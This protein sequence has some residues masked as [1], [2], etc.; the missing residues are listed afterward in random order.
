VFRRIRR[1][2]VKI[3]VLNNK[4]RQVRKGSHL[5]AGP[6]H[7]SISP[8]PRGQGEAIDVMRLIV[9]LVVALL[10]LLKFFLPHSDC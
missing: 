8:R 4:I 9:Q 1:T 2:P 7:R 3:R 10:P 5:S 6:I